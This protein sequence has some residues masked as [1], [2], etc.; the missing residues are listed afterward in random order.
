MRK[1]SHRA[2]GVHC[3]LKSELES[4]AMA[5]PAKCDAILE[6][7]LDTNIACMKLSQNSFSTML[8]QQRAEVLGLN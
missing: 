5:M 3:L 1:R 7:L 8:L 2:A 4:P 6:Q